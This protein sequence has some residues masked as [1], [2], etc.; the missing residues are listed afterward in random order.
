LLIAV[1]KDETQVPER[2][3]ALVE[4]EILLPRR[5]GAEI[6]YEFRHALLQRMAHESM[7]QTERRAMHVRIVEVLLNATV[8]EPAIPEVLAHHLTEAGDFREAVEAWLQAGVAAARRSAHVEAVEHIRSGLGLL[9]RIPDPG[10]RRQFELNLQASLMGS[11]LATL[12]ATSPELAACCERGLQLCEESGAAAM[13][14]PFAF[15]QFTFVNCRGRTSEAIVLARQ[16]VSLAE[17]GGFAPERVIGQRMLGQALLVKGDAAAAKMALER[18]AALYIPERDAATT[19]LY[20]QNTEIHTKSLLSLTHLLLGDVD[21]ALE[22]GLDALRAADAIQ[23]PHSTAIPMSYVGGWVFGLCGAAAEMLTVGRSLLA[24][25]EQHRLYGFRAHAAAYI[26]WALCLGGNP[27]EGIP[28]IAKAIAAFDSVQF[29]LGG[30]GHLANLADAQ[31]RVGRL[32]EAAATCERALELM[33]EGSQLLEPEVRRVH[34]LVAAELAPTDRDRAEGLL[35]GA[36]RCARE[37]GFPVFERRCLV[38]LAQFLGSSGR[39]DA[40]VTSRLGELS[41]LDGLD[42]RVARAMQKFPHV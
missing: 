42:R 23:H 35:R 10:A 32:T 7:V 31:R 4:A 36:V 11:L 2:L 37:Y 3:E 6:R 25:A 29:R 19:H 1:L 30:G 27:D 41:H 17:Q 14:F 18:S 8:D 34:A 24:L 22:V 39:S 12:S 9:G 26:G 5:F 16:F 38:S 21:A 13:V 20:G 15:G 28:M 40:A 33:P